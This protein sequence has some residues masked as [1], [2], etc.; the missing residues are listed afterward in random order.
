MAAL[1]Q[2]SQSPRGY[3]LM[4]GCGIPPGVPAQNLL[5]LKKAVLDFKDH[6]AS[7]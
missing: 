4:P 1:A 7:T 2:G 6:L 5:M 3:I